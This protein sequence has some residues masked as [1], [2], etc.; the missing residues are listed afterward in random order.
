MQ[1]PWK[2]GSFTLSNLPPPYS[3]LHKNQRNPNQNKPFPMLGLD[4]Y[5]FLDN[6]SF[7]VCQLKVKCMYSIHINQKS[8]GC[9]CVIQE[10]KGW[11][12][13]IL[14]W[15]QQNKVTEE[16]HV[17]SSAIQIKANARLHLG[18]TELAGLR[19]SNT[20]LLTKARSRTCMD[21]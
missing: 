20:S 11:R 8:G 2:P 14:I 13:F 3:F 17:C 9:T 6:F 12:N 18:T 21:T 10:I 4:I 19:S 1:L 16:Q 15:R 7:C 5:F